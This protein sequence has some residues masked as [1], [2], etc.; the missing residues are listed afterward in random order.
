LQ[1]K[2]NEIHI[3][4]DFNINPM[5]AV[6]AVIENDNVFIFDEIELFSSDTNEMCQHVRQKYPEQRITV[7]PDPA[8]RQRRTSATGG[9]TDL[10]ILKGGQWR[11]AVR[12][13]GSHAS[14]RDRVNAV[15][16]KL[17]SVAGIR[18]LFVSRKCKK[19]IRSLERQIYKEGTGLPDKTSGYDHMNDAL[20][21]LIEYLYPVAQKSGTVEIGGY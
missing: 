15:N 11:F 18:S 8:V 20:G 4:M 2:T 3:G 21:Y 13:K 1:I 16:S 19:L 7:Y 6:F 14:I 10:T 9:V 12:V 17:C 5:T